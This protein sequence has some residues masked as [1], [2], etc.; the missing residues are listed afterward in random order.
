M[1]S[2]SF[3][4]A[5]VVVRAA[6]QLFTEGSNNQPSIVADYSESVISAGEQYKALGTRWYL[7]IFHV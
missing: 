3:N 6:N 5:A 2:G 7:F 1:S 4:D